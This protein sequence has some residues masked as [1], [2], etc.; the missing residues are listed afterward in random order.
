MSLALYSLATVLIAVVF[1]WK[2]PIGAL[3]P[4][5]FRAMVA[6]DVQD[7]RRPAVRNQSDFAKRLCRN[8]DGQQLRYTRIILGGVHRDCSM[9]G[10]RTEKKGRNLHDFRVISKCLVGGVTGHCSSEVIKT[11]KWLYETAAI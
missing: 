2:E 11:V 3:A 10:I 5:I 1:K 9:L 7:N 8:L 4:R 6:S